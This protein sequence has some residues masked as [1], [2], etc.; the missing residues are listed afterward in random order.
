VICYRLVCRGSSFKRHFGS[1]ILQNSSRAYGKEGNFWQWATLAKI[2]E[3]VFGN[4]DLKSDRKRLSTVFP[5]LKSFLEITDDERLGKPRCPNNVSSW[6]RRGSSALNRPP[7][8]T[9]EGRRT[10]LRHILSRLLKARKKA[11]K[12]LKKSRS[13]H[14]ESR[15]SRMTLI[16]ESTVIDDSILIDESIVLEESTLIEEFL[17]PSRAEPDDI[18]R[19]TDSVELI[20][21]Q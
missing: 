17:E 21:D 4:R 15:A 2:L 5:I 7:N 14:G 1:A 9:S 6:L 11:S 12:A 13:L 18:L 20:G 8:L 10:Y 19:E 3:D 16:A